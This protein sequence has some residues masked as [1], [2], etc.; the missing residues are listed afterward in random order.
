MNFIKKALAGILAS[1]TIFLFANGAEAANGNAEVAEVY[2]ANHGRMDKV[3]L[4]WEVVPKA[5]RYNFYILKGPEDNYG[6]IQDVVRN[7]YTN[8]YEL[9]ASAYGADKWGYYWKARAFD[10]D[11]NIIKDTEVK[12]IIQGE[13]NTKTVKS[14]TEFNEMDYMPLYPVFSWVPFN[15]ASSYDIQVYRV[16]DGNDVRIRELKDL[17]G[18]NFY[19][20]GGYTH[21]GKYYWKILPK[22][23]AGVPMAEWSEPSHFEITDY[24]PVAA[25]G[26][27]I[28][29]G[30]GSV[31]VPP[32]YK[33]FDWE[34]YCSVPV[35]NLGLSGDT[36][37][38]MSERFEREVLPFAPKI[39]VIMGGVNNYREGATAWQV[40]SGLRTLN[41][42]CSTYGI[43]PVFLT[44]TPLNPDK[45]AKVEGIGAPSYGWMDEQ[46]AVNQWI[47]RQPHHIDVA[48]SLTDGRGWLSDDT[49]TDGLHP[50]LP[51]KKIIGEKVGEYLEKHFPD[52]A[53]EAKSV[54]EKNKNK[55]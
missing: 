9:D 35:K 48:S 41:S 8:G 51:G 17:T 34:S 20:Y 36:V 24:A 10:L 28:T 52:I 26:D 6:N 30:G 5:V 33:I 13:I 16:R 40:I 50:D 29:H 19:E 55:E 31:I 43:I 54:V 21:A 25:L 1:M 2:S 37:E 23:S 39:L 3:R 27:S 45:I 53:K 49:T 12:P 42:K 18:N 7:V 38:G 15:G 14:T 46:Q 22:N 47:R 11:G 4:E 32:S 44:V